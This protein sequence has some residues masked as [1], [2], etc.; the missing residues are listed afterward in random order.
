M[1][2]IRDHVCTPEGP[3]VS[4]KVRTL[5]NIGTGENTTKTSG[6]SNISGQTRV[7][8][9]NTLALDSWPLSILLLHSNPASIIPLEEFEKIR[10]N[11]EILNFI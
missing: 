10:A 11:F 6:E 2:R 8:A 9:S 4:G 3:S 7:S 1:S 5:I